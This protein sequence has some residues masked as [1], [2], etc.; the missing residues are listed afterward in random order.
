MF[1][2]FARFSAFACLRPHRGTL[3]SNKQHVFFA[4]RSF[5]FVTRRECCLVIGE[6]ML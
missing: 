5:W 1:W 6:W 4:A 2:C 3:P